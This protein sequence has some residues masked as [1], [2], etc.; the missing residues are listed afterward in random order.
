MRIFHLNPIECDPKYCYV[1]GSFPYD[2]KLMRGGEVLAEMEADGVSALEYDL[3]EDEGGLEVGDFFTNVDNHLPV[4][5]K[6][7]DSIADRFD[8]GYCEF[9]PGLVRNAKGR[10]HVSDMVILNPVEAV[11]CLDWE[12]S[13]INDDDD[14]P[15]VRIFGKW[16]LKAGQIPDGR[17]LFRVKGL[18]GYCFS[19]RLVEFIGQ[20]GMTNFEFEEA[21]LS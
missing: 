5:R 19:E 1:S 9:I 18:I 6:F 16:S 3:D 11:D 13:D 14:Y 7:A 20:Q 10:V 15:M 12:D 17:D 21:R 8:L 4:T 2:T